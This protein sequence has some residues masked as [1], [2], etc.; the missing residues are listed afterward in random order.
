MEE[1]A[2]KAAAARLQKVRDNIW[3]YVAIAV[4]VLVIFFV[5]RRNWNK[6]KGTFAKDY[7]D[8]SDGTPGQLSP[9]RKAY[10]EQ[11]A[12]NLKTAMEATFPGS[13]RENYMSQA[14]ALPDGELKY[15][16]NYFKNALTRDESLYYWVDWEIMPGSSADDELCTRLA[17]IG[18]TE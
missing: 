4:V 17:A 16:A 8:Y 9:A 7:G 10:L 11:L 18:E 14:T 6:L 12:K 5:L 3:L 15:L 2:M 13:D 1:K